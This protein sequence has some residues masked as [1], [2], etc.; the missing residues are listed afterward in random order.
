M[1]WVL[2]FTLGVVA[3]PALKAPDIKGIEREPLEV[4]AGHLQAIFF[5]D[6]TCPVSNYYSHEIRRICDAYSSRGVGCALVYVDPTLS[7]EKAGKHAAEYGHGDYPK[8]VDRKHALV[9]ATRVNVTPE[10]VILKP[11]GEIAYR[12]RIDNFYADFGKP[13]RVATEHD[14]R[15]ALDAVLA[16]K[17]APHPETKPVGCYIPELKFYGR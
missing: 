10:A 13:R 2:L 6:H 17:P 4:T 7:D 8:I 15:D 1:K 11:R 16:G 14:L 5:V 3:H 12:G 9:A